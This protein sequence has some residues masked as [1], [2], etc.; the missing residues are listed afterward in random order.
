MG[1][2]VTFPLHQHSIF[3]FSGG[4]AVGIVGGGMELEPRGCSPEWT[5][6]G[7]IGNRRQMRAL[8]I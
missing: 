7:K 2:V 6:A 5:M 8:N 3:K 4:S 1:G